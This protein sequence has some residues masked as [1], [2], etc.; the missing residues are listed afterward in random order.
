MPPM[1]FGGTYTLERVLGTVPVEADGSAYMELPALRSLFFVALDEH[2]NSVKRMMSFLTV[3]P[4]ETT[5]CVGC[6]EQRTADAAERRPQPAARR[7]A[8]G[9]ARS[10]P[11]PASPTCSTSRATSSRSSTSTACGATTTTGATAGWSLTGDRGPIYSHSYYTLTA[12]GQVSDGRDRL[13]TNLPPRAIGTSASPLMD[14][15]DARHYE[16]QLSPHEQDMI[17]YWIESAAAVSGHLRGAGHRDDRRL[18]QE[19]TRHQRP[20]VARVPSLRPRPFAA[21]AWAATTSRMPMPQYL[22]DDLGL[23]LSNPDPQDVRMRWSRHLMFNLSRPERS[24]I[25]LA[26]LAQEAGGYGLCRPKGKSDSPA[27]NSSNADLLAMPVSVFANTQD[28]DYQ[29]ILTLCREGKTYLDRIKRFDMPGF[30]P[31]AMYVREMQRFGI[32]PQE[33]SQD[34]LIDIHA[35]DQAYWQ[36]LWWRPPGTEP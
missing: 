28:A 23:V 8:A 24:L 34:D 6:H 29:K 1:S 5:G 14:K 20:P 7:C 15:L 25:L 13:V 26:P 22:S 36:S 30:R 31:P 35:T 21:V 32:L 12:L 2:D 9:R 3:M 10:R 19:P 18:S 17:R 4:G 11:S 27:S 16:V 33:F